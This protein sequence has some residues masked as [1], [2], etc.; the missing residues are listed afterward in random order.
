MGENISVDECFD[1][2]TPEQK[3]T[4]AEMV[5][6]DCVLSGIWEDHVYHF[7]LEG[8]WLPDT[9]KASIL[10][11]AGEIAQDTA[12]FALPGGSED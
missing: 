9:L 10:N 6:A 1:R 5:A 12:S 7:L 3:S 11:R 8:E 2:F 4:L